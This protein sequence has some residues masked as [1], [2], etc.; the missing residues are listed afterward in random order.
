MRHKG[1]TIAGIGLA[2]AIAV[3]VY[4][5]TRANIS[6]LPGP[7]PFE[8]FVA[9]LAKDWCVSRAA[10]G[11]LPAP[12]ANDAASVAAGSALFG[13]GCSSCHGQ[14][15]RTP[16]PIG[17]SMYPRSLD[18]GS[19]DVQEMTDREL[20]WVVRNGIRLSGMPGFGH[21]NSDEQI[22]QLTYY[23]RSLGRQAKQ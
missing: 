17:K 9:T 11:P 21:I 18:L 14:D 16:T 13:M 6:A 1:W 22:W 12:P 7:G 5:A 8:T 3:A 4:A 15:G 10:R 19:T 20:F 2:L 23:V